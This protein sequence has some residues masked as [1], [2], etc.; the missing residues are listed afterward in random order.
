MVSS[1]KNRIFIFV[2][3]FFLVRCVTSQYHASKSNA[4]GTDIKVSP[5][6]VVA[7]C[8]FITDYTGDYFEPHGF[9]IHILDAEKTVLT[10]SNGTVLD[11][12]E[13][14][15]RLKATEE[16]LK[17]GN[18]V[19]VRG[20]GDADAPIRLKS[21]TYFFPKHGRFPDNG[22][23]LNYLAI[24]NDLGQCYDAFYGSEKPCPREK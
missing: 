1:R 24:W 13:C 9:M 3:S 4:F 16:I 19:F 23:N 11:K 7:E 8:E 20:R 18:T 22:R 2:V 6:R 5:D 10:V 12:K 14:F 17:K 15:K 21:N